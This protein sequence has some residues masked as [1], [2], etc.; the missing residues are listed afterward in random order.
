MRCYCHYQVPLFR[1]AAKPDCRLERRPHLCLITVAH[2]AAR[3]TDSAH[4]ICSH[5]SVAHML[6]L[7]LLSICVVRNVFKLGCALTSPAQT[8]STTQAD[9]V[10][11]ALTG[12]G[13]RGVHKPHY[14]PSFSHVPHTITAAHAVNDMVGAGGQTHS[15]LHHYVAS[16]P[17]ST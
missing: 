11:Q 9:E 1:D 13:V 10:I 4:C 14:R 6:L 7:P 15:Q 12:T 17:H 16:C 8:V 3:S 2:A 5:V